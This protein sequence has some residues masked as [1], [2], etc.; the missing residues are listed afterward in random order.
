MAL[1]DFIIVGA[2]KCGTTT[3]AAQLGAQPGIFM[4]TPKEP[5]FFSD[6]A[7]YAKGLDW[8]EH[9]FD[10]AL[11]G[12]IKGEASTHYTKLP[13]YPN[14]IDRLTAALKEPKIIYLIRDPLV[15]TVSQYMHEWSMGTLTGDYAEIFPDHPELISYSCYGEQIAP[16]VDAYGAENILVTSLED[17]SIQ[18]RQI[19]NE[20]CD[21]LGYEGQPMW[22]E[23][24]SKLNISAERIRR[25]PLHDILID[26][27]VATTLRRSL[28]P[29]ALRNKIKN[30]R[31]LYDRPAPPPGLK[32]QL[33]G[34]F[35]QDYDVLRSFFPDSD[36]IDASYR[37]L[38]E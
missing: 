8:Y 28:V 37:F 4:S 10:E 30:A 22:H 25:F 3:L 6:D 16:Y 34:V 27:T 11:P 23:E 35:D 5:N 13:T 14:C 20:V 17:L 9:L 1:P 2:M 21:F 24:K 32:E 12:D 7:V 19:L 36:R 29:R 26:N 33:R 31:R 38:T 18:P 15:R